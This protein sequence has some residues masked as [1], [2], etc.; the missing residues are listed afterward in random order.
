MRGSQKIYRAGVDVVDLIIPP[1]A[2]EVI[3]FAQGFGN[4]LAVDPVDDVDI[5]ACPA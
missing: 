2:E 4:V 3:D 5:L 1:I